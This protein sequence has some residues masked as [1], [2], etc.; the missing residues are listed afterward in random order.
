MGFFPFPWIFFPSINFNKGH[1]TLELESLRDQESFW[2]DVNLQKVLHGMWWRM[3][4]GIPDFVSSPPR[5]GG[6][7]TKLGDH[8]NSKSH[9]PWFTKSYFVEEPTW[10]GWLSHYTW[11][12]VTTQHFHG[13]YLSMSFK[14][15][16]NFILTAL[17]CNEKWQRSS[18]FLRCNLFFH[19]L[20]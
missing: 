12:L 14:G 19:V 8:D 16:H 9:N 17:V 15:S 13:M 11:R 5:R 6:S 3:F 20:L 2:M 1:F 4:C 7:N 10:L 18:L